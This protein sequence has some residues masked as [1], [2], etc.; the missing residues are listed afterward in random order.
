MHTEYQSLIENNT[1]D[2][3]DQASCEN[4][5]V[6][7]G[8]WVFKLKK[9]RNGNILKYKARWVV[10][11]Y[12]Q[13]EGVDYLDTFAVVVK[14]VSYKAIMAISIKKGYIIKHMDV[15]TAFL[16]GFLDE[17]IYVIQLTGFQQDKKICK[18]RKALYGLKQAPRVWYQTIHDF[19]R[20]LNF[21]RIDT[22]HGVYIREDMIIAIYVDDLLISGSSLIIMDE[23]Q[24]HL[25]NRFRITDLDI[26]P[27]YLGME[28]NFSPKEEIISIH[29]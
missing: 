1:W 3:V 2:L 13:Q 5:E 17:D 10:H 24:R 15:V 9:D 21:E 20:K 16:Y 19:L 29:Q 8:K 7:T 22:D 23:V 4:Q 6:I 12:K 27:H 25:G 11:G 28:I 14:P 26:I 18:L